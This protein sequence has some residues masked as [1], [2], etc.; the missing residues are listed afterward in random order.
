MG[1]IDGFQLVLFEFHWKL[2]PQ[3]NNK[4]YQSLV[5]NQSHN[6]DPIHDSLNMQITNENDRNINFQ[7][8]LIQLTF[9]LNIPQF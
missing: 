2:R 6:N 3:N 9:H 5:Y 1:I 8:V 4:I 7:P